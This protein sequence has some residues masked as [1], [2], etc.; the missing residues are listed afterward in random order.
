MERHDIADTGRVIGFAYLS[1]YR[2]DRIKF[3]PQGDDEAAAPALYHS[4]SHK[5]RLSHA[6]VLRAQAD[7][8]L[9][10]RRG[11]GLIQRELIARR[12]LRGDAPLLADQFTAQPVHGSDERG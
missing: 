7:S 4:A 11:G 6:D 2:D 1:I 9:T 5:P 3:E 10:G 12:Q 8:S